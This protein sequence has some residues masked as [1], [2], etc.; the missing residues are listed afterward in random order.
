VV[1]IIR[2]KPVIQKTYDYFPVFSSAR[3][4]IAVSSGTN[5]KHIGLM[6]RSPLHAFTLI[7]LLVVIAIIA[8]LMAILMPA[9]QRVRKQAKATACQMNLHQWALVFEMYTGDYDG[10]F[11]PG[12]D[13]DWDTA[14]YSWIYTLMPYYTDLEIRLCPSAS[15]TKSQ[16]G[17]LPLAA[18]DM[19]ESN[20]GELSFLKD[21]RYK[22]G[23][24]GINWWVNDSDI[25]V[26]AGLDKKDKW[27]RT[28]QKNPGMIPVLMD[29]GFM[30][31]R[32]R[33]FNDPPPYDGFFAWA[34][35]ARGIDRVCTNRHNG[36]INI[37]FTNWSIRK[38]G[39]K[40]LWTL[41]WHRSYDVNGPWTRSGGVL[42][43]EWP[44]WMKRFKDY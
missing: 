4:E 39:L 24:Y 7:E 14:R 27:R 18:W 30:L 10:R 38:I 37:M 11:M 20:P 40:E 23:S 41:K 19:N 12:I 29:C 2:G 26:G 5:G 17:R 1:V 9:L 31:A 44:D 13:E 42:E 35:G 25:A 28:G 33:E 34:V 21:D 3:K 43:S 8:L 6:P 22:S 15:R 16:G 32:P 36:G